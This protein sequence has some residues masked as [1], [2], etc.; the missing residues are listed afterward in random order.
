MNAFLEKLKC[1]IFG[2][3]FACESG[4]ILSPSFHILTAAS[5]LPST[6]NPLRISQLLYDLDCAIHTS[7]SSPPI[8]ALVEELSL[9]VFGVGFSSPL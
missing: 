1:S 4:Y 7:L 3:F 9:K 5:G 6:K 2:G 8:I